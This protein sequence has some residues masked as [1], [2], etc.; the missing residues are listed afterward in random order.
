MCGYFCIV[1]D[2]FMFKG[3]TLACF[4]N[5]FWPHKFKENEEVILNYFLKN[6]IN[7]SGRTFLQLDK[8]QT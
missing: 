3:K 7:M 4:T 6:N 2:D 8:P 1:F 5:L